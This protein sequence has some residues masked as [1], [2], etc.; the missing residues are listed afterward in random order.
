M[1]YC[2]ISICARHGDAADLHP[3]INIMHGLW[4]DA[5]LAPD[6]CLCLLCPDIYP[7][8][9]AIYVALDGSTCGLR[10]VY[11]YIY[12]YCLM[13]DTRISGALATGDARVLQRAIDIEH[14]LWPGVWLVPSSCLYLRWPHLYIPWNKPHVW[15]WNGSICD[16]WV[17]YACYTSGWFDAELQRIQCVSNGDATVS[18]Q[19]IDIVHVLGLLPDWYQATVYIYYDPIYTPWSKPYVLHWNVSTCDLWVSYTKL[20]HRDVLMLGYGIFSALAV[21]MLQPCAQT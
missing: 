15:H 17:S 9:L 3:T 19:T 21:V 11:G 7:M 2:S 20:I 4:P 13:R 6:H 5:W 1:L 18:Q 8:R 14:W 10:V 16:L 12:Q